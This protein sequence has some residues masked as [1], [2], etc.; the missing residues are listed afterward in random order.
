M[1]M[2]LEKKDASSALQRSLSAV[3]YWSVPAPLLPC[4]PPWFLLR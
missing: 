1:D 4:L 2:E 3:T